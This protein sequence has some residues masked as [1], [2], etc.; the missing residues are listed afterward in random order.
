MSEGSNVLLF[1]FRLRFFP[2]PLDNTFILVRYSYGLAW[3]LM[4][5]TL[6][7]S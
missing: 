6:L 3:L 7:T 1:I 2:F 5:D 4:R